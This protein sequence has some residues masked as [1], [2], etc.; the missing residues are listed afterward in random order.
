[1]SKDNYHRMCAKYCINAKSSKTKTTHEK[2][3]ALGNVRS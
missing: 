3:Y 1:M 2:N